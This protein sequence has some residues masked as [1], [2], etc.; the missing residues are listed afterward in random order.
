MWDTGVQAIISL[1]DELQEGPGLHISGAQHKTLALDRIWGRPVIL[2]LRR[3]RQEDCKSE[4][5]LLTE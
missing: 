5:S 2:P 1:S 4:A 3:L